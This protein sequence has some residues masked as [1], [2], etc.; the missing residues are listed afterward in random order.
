MDD[1]VHTT[2][3][4]LLIPNSLLPKGVNL[5]TVKDKNNSIVKKLIY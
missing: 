4:R 2:T 5:I 3:N 1:M